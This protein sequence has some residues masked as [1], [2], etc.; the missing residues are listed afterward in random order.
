MSTLGKVLLFLNLL[1]AA[2]LVY[3]S[4]QDWARRQE[5]S[6]VVLRYHLTL[7]GVPVETPKGASDGDNAVLPIEIQSPAGVTLETAT[8]KLLKAHYTGFEGGETYGATGN[9]VI[10]LSL[11]KE[12]DR[13]EKKLLGQV[14]SQQGDKA[15]LTL[16][17]GGPDAQARFQ[18]GVLLNMAE[19]FEERLAIRS[20]NYPA[21]GDE[22]AKKNVE[23]ARARLVRKIEALKAAPAPKEID[24]VTAEVDEL[25]KAIENDPADAA[26]KAKLA[27]ISG[28]GAPAFTRD[29]GDRRRRIV[30]FLA[31]VD[32]S[33]AWQKRVAVVAGLRTYTATLSEQS[34]RLTDI[35]RRVERAI[36]TDQAA[37][38]LEYETMKALAI[39]QDVLVTD[40]QINQKGRAEMEALD[41]ASKAGRAAQLDALKKQ[42]ADLQNTIASTLARQAEAEKAVFELQRKV[43]QTL[44]GNLDLEATLD[45][46]EQKK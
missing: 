26:A 21:A 1:A 28:L 44:R 20:L 23:D 35:A 7:Q 37:F 31:Q 29:E 27:A 2:G 46:A 14:D 34:A 43:G 36:E 24:K 4:S 30:L 8:V 17:V 42:L 19:S 38:E 40:E 12:L 32:S 45:R 15:K 9:D 13:V 5:I 3:V 39:K 41:A 33:A 10:A 11:V 25:K 18:P 6:G 22:L 16:L